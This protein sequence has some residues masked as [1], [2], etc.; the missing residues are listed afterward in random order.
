MEKEI[1]RV[2]ERLLAVTLSYNGASDLF[3]IELWDINTSVNEIPR[4]FVVSV[5]IGRGEAFTIS[6]ATGVQI[7]VQ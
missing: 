4:E 7:Y 6:K 2:N 3:F 5:L 1:L